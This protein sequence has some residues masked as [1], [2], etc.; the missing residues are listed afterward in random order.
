[1]DGLRAAFAALLVVS[2]VLGGTTVLDF[3]DRLGAIDTAAVVDGQVSVELVDASLREDRFVATVRFE[4]PTGVD[5]RVRSAK[6]RIYNASEQRIASGAGTRLDD[7]GATLP[8]RGSLTTTYEIRVAEERRGPLRAALRR[9]AR[10][11]V[12]VGMTVD[13][14]DFSLARS[15][16]NASEAFREGS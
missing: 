7:N 9:D 10:L 6:L 1:M 12:S 11:A 5:L 14:L 3:G 15:G 2:V 8:A 4:N 13:D 16:M